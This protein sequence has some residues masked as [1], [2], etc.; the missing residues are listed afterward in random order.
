MAKRNSLRFE[1]I[2]ANINPGLFVADAALAEASV[3]SCPQLRLVF[4]CHRWS[5]F[6]FGGR[7]ASRKTGIECCA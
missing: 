2:G 1:R 3:V 4:A 5:L 6:L 7:F